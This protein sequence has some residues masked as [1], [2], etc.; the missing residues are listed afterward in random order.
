M[1]K[2][3]GSKIFWSVPISGH[4]GTASRPAHYLAGRISH[5]FALLFPTTPDPSVIPLAGGFFA[6]ERRP[7]PAH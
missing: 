1:V 4:T 6:E 2:I 3:F 5:L 7:Q